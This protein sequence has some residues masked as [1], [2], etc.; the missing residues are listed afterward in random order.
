MRGITV[1]KNNFH[2][3]EVQDLILKDC[4]DYPPRFNSVPYSLHKL[5][6]DSGEG[7]EVEKM[8][9]EQKKGN[10]RLGVYCE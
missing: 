5:V 6:R 9:K 10:A 2:P 4:S 8:R 3:F 1:L 7:K